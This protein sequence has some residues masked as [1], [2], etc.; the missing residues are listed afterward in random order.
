M[1]G[2]DAEIAYRLREPVNLDALQRLFA[3]SWP[4]GQPKSSYERVL[5]RA[6][7]WVT[8]HDRGELIGFVN[9]AWDGGVHFFLLDTTV[10][11]SHR[12]QGVGRHL[13]ETAIEACRGHGEWIHV[14]ADE[15]LM[16]RLYWP[17]GFG[18][19]YAGVRKL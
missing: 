11:P 15:A 6:F 4:E 3:A 10:A 13:V 5:D 17:A 12:G 9:I 7:T 8:A 16:D 14:D 1:A 18:V 19:A 2:V